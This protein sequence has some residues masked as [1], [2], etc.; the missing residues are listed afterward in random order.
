MRILIAEDDFVSRRVLTR[1]LSEYGSCDVAVDG[2]N[3]VEIFTQALDEERPY[4]LVCLDIIMPEMDGLEALGVIRELEEAQGIGGLEGTKV[5]M[6]TGLDDSHAVLDAFRSGCEGYVVKPI[7]RHKIAEQ[8][9][10]LG[11]RDTEDNPA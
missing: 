1:V 5:I 4:D 7:D 10:Q 11:L 9:E 6:T 3:A 2:K 8:L